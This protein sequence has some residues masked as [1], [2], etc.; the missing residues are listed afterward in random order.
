ML[1][2]VI[3]ELNFVNLN[4]DIWTLF[5]VRKRKKNPKQRNE[6]STPDLTSV[7][8]GKIGNKVN[9]NDCLDVPHP[10]I[11]NIIQ[12]PNWDKIEINVI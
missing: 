7:C 12:K 5:L 4:Q 6:I 9:A 8:L 11:H 3:S 10:S 1:H 2:L